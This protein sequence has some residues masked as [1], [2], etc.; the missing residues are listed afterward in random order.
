MFESKPWLRFYGSTPAA[1]TYPPVS[2]YG[3]LHQRAAAAPDVTALIFMGRRI[4]HGELDRR[5]CRTSRGLAALGMKQG[6]RVLV[7]LP[8]VPQAVQVLYALCRIGAVPAMIHPLSAPA[9]IRGYASQAGCTWAVTLDAFYPRFSEARPDTPLTRFILCRVADAMGPLLALGYALTEGRKIPPVPRDP[10]ITGWKELERAAAEAPELAAPDPLSPG[11]T[12]VLLFSGGTTGAA[13]AIMLSSSNC[14]ALALQT[15][16]AGGPILPGD[17]MLSILPM[18]HGFGL[19]VGIHAVLIS[20][21]T[22]ILVPRFNADEMAA[23]V[24]KYRPAYLAGVPTLFDV[25][26]ANRRFQSVQMGSFKGLFCGGDSLSRQTKERFEAV[27]RKGGGNTP[28]REGY[29]LTESVTANMLMPRDHYREGSMGIP[30][31]DM[32]AKVV[33]PGTMDEAPPGTDGEICVSGPTIMLGYLDDP[34]DTAEALRTHADGALWLHTADIGTMDADGFFYFKQRAKRII[35]TS[36][37]SV[38]PSQIEAVLARHPAVRLCCVIGVSHPTQVQVPKGFV[39]LNDGWSAGPG[40]ERELIEHCRGE[41]LPHACPRS[42]EFRDRLPLTL[43]GKV[44][45]RLLEEQEL[46]AH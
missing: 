45:Y 2:L 44:A 12:A 15:N 35:K 26:A 21:G 36:G 13:K 30:Y 25:L 37:I 6:D 5:I 42:M 17:A 16:A 39:T 14:N 20:G 28:L 41:L 1:L 24:K 11:E 22:C 4:S 19:A 38:Y 46:K 10:D 23:L 40:L 32:M 7:C 29:G 27:V 8:N 33:L 3:A 43:V 9:E 18:F 34:A 31:P